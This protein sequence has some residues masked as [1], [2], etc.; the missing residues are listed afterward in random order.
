[1]TETQL[2]PASGEVTSP[3]AA[4]L[5]TVV[6]RFADAKGEEFAAVDGLDLRI[7]RGE[8]VAFL[9]PN[10]AG[11]TTTIDMLLGSPGP[12]RAGWSC[13]ARRHGRRCAPDGSRRSSR[14]A[15]CCPT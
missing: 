6:K 11:K 15:D 5:S 8:V 12:T 13:S 1:M 4:V 14:A 7:R 9:G 2:R 10:G 3:D